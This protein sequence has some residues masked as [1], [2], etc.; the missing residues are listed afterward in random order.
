[1]ES[2]ALGGKELGVDLG[3]GHKLSRDKCDKALW[4]E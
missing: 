1:M 3:A 2:C 4:V